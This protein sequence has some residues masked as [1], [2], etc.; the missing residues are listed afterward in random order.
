[1]LFICI[2]CRLLLATDNDSEISSEFS[3][4]QSINFFVVQQIIAQNSNFWKLSQIHFDKES[5]FILYIRIEILKY[6]VNFFFHHFPIC[7]CLFYINQSFQN[8]KK[9][10]VLTNLCSIFVKIYSVSQRV[11]RRQKKSIT[12]KTKRNLASESFHIYIFFSV[13]FEKAIIYRKLR[14]PTLY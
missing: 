3:K 11:R 2:V 9:I 8:K 7:D 5:R 14:K 12:K 1:M 4:I 13:N 6:A 10:K